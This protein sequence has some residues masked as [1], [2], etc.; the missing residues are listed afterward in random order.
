M[1]VMQK[2]IMF[3]LDYNMSV[4]SIRAFSCIQISMNVLLVIILVSKSV[5]TQRAPTP[6]NVAMAIHL[7][8]TNVHV[9]VK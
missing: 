3:L 5:L 7:G 9:K 1:F 4:C 2:I 6:V 8:E